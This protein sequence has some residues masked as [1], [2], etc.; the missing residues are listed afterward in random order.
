MSHLQIAAF[1][2]GLAAYGC[3]CIFLGCCVKV[4]RS[5]AGGLA[6][7]VGAICAAAAGVFWW[8]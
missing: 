4:D 2:L 3:F 5:G 7:G 1:V 6:A 8:M